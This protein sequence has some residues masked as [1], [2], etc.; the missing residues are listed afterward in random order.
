[1]MGHGFRTTGDSVGWKCDVKGREKAY[2]A[3]HWCEVPELIMEVAERLRGVQIECMNALELIPRFNAPEVLIYADPPYVMSAR[4]GRAQYRHEMSDA[5]HKVLLE[6][7][8]AH[9]GPVVLSGYDS[10]LYNDA[11][12]SWHREELMVRDQAAQ[13]RREILW[14]NYEPQMTL[15]DAI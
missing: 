12:R 10:P 2:A 9:K 1:M 5:D 8:L 11:L 13:A 6:V 7:L 4:S 15:F 3:L 14:L